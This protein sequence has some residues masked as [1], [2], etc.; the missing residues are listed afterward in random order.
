MWTHQSAFNSDKTNTKTNKCV[1][2]GLFKNRQFYR[3]TPPHS[4]VTDQL[5]AVCIQAL[6]FLWFPGRH[7]D[8]PAL[9]LCHHLCWAK[10]DSRVGTATVDQLHQTLLIVQP[11]T[12]GGAFT[13]HDQTIQ[14]I[15]SLSSDPTTEIRLQSGTVQYWSPNLGGGIRTRTEG[16]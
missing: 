14:N 2:S 16:G 1:W 15:N 11:V 4:D 8:T 12:G 13:S 10:E 9:Q 3:A 6:W 7:G 5:E